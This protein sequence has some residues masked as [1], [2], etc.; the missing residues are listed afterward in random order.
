[1]KQDEELDKKVH[2]CLNMVNLF[3]VDI[4]N[5]SYG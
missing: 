4:C 5:A 1:M 2:V 3:S